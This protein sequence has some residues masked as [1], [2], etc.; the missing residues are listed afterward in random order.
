MTRARK[1]SLFFKIPHFNKKLCF[2]WRNPGNGLKRINQL[3]Y[4]CLIPMIIDNKHKNTRTNFST[5]SFGTRLQRQLAGLSEFSNFHK[6][7]CAP[8]V[9]PPK[10]GMVEIGRPR[11]KCKRRTETNVFLRSRLLP[12]EH[13]VSVN[14]VEI[15]TLC[16]AHSHTQ[17]EK[18]EHEHTAELSER[19]QNNFLTPTSHCKSRS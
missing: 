15:W 10:M 6:V 1:L 14:R 17:L 8:I 11:E 7:K 3:T 18:G 9:T 5:L 2:K 12:K 13:L 16:V 4:Y 19:R